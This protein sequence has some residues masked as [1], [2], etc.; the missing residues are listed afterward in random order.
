MSYACGSRRRKKDEEERR[1]KMMN[2]IDLFK[3]GFSNMLKVNGTF[4]VESIRILKGSSLKLFELI[5]LFLWE[6]F[7]YLTYRLSF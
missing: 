4:G 1:R 5:C 3:F 7:L 2:E 6:L